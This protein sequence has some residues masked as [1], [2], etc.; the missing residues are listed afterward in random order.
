MAQPEIYPDC[1]ARFIKRLYPR[2]DAIS[3]SEFAVLAFWSNPL[4]SHE[5]WLARLSANN[6]YYELY[7]SQPLIH[8]HP[9]ALLDHLPLEYFA[10]NWP[11][12]RLNC[13]KAAFRARS[14]IDMA[15]SALASGVLLVPPEPQYLD[16]SRGERA[17]MRAIGAKYR[18]WPNEIASFS[19]L[20]LEDAQTIAER[21]IDLELVVR[22]ADSRLICAQNYRY[23]QNELPLRKVRYKVG[24]RIIEKTL[25]GP[26]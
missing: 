13:R 20:P 24:G 2:Y 21:L 22:L 12:I 23:K 25:G 5:Q 8:I 11:I 3:W 17:V 26:Y 4:F 9:A 6:P 18:S 16:L 19:G 15:W 10:K 1:M 7:L 14:V